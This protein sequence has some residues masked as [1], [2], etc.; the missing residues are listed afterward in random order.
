[1]ANNNGSAPAGQKKKKKKVKKTGA[2]RGFFTLLFTIFLVIMMIG[3]LT[4]AS[5]AM[6]VFVDLGLV[7]SNK[8]KSVEEEIASVDYLDLDMY[9]NNQEKTTIIYKYNAEG[10]LVEDTRLHGSENRL[11]ASIDEIPLHTQQA[12]IA[13][14]DE[15]FYDHRGVD[16][17]GTI[18][19]VVVDI[20]GGDLQGG[21]T[22]TQQLI[23]N[24]TGENKRTVIR[25]YREIKSALALERHFTKAQI[26]EA[27]LNT[28]YLDQGC[29]GIKTG[30]EYYFGK[31]VSELTL[32]ESAILVSITNAPRKFDPI[33]N[34][35]NNAER[36]NHCLANMLEQGYI[37]QE[38]YDAAL[39]E[40]VEFVGKLTKKNDE[41]EEDDTG[42]EGENGTEETDEQ[43]YQSWY[44]DLTIET[45][46][47]DLTAA[48]PITRDQAWRMVYFSGLQIYSAVD[49]EIQHKMEDIY[50]TRRGLPAEDPDDDNPLQS[51]CVVMDYEG[52]ILGVT[53][54]LDPKVG[55]RL[56]SY[57]TDDPRNPGSSIK[58][59]SCYA[60]AIDG[61]YF[62]W[63]SYLPNWGIE[64][65]WASATYGVWPSNYG[66]NYG[67]PADMR[68]LADAIAPSLNTIPARIIQRIGID[69]SYSYLRDRFHLSTLLP[70]DEGYAALAIG[71]FT[72]GV[73]PLEMCA[74]YAV[75]G[76][77]GNYY[78]PYCYY[79]VRDSDGNVILKPDHTKSKSI[80]ESTAEVMLHLLQC[81]VYWPSG[82][83]YPFQVS[84][85]TTY[86]K[87]GTSS[88]N[89]DKWV[90]GGTPY[91]VCATWTGF[92]YNQE[93]TSYYGRNPAGTLFKEVMDDIHEGL[94]DKE[95]ERSSEA[96][97]RTYCELSGDLASEYCKATATGWYRVD[98]LPT[99]CTSCQYAS[100]QTTEGAR[101]DNPIFR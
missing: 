28:M 5:V 85:Y 68:N 101:P 4:A 17:I 93:I 64:V 23:K 58:P 33:I 24:L 91:Y 51:A 66:G 50:Y 7:D 34:P 11:I 49:D 86:G 92:K 2:I 70:N 81:P 61:K 76:N 90:C 22:I 75:F 72:D 95:F 94:P 53:G 29:Y 83:V 82:T 73:T 96:V 57:A 38:E 98:D 89:Y 32:M 10:E 63:S 12:V 56:L 16:W 18:R 55:N 99:V 97:A 19:S 30:A 87:S 48:Y 59:L 26:L 88:K 8:H 41:P 21:S 45:V 14:E 46:I 39:D 13:L 37:T 36:A 6:T 44:T 15:R 20:T 77:G 3:L 35:E 67:D 43:E 62:Y 78:K 40:K 25:K 27:Y 71:E 1:M 100:E 80:E 79:E 69:F 84:G 31:D 9:L 52:R 74:A 65:P 47:S 42:E 60:P 54:A